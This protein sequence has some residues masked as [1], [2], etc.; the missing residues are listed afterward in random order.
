LFDLEKDPFEKT[1]LAAQNPKVVAEIIA[2]MEREHKAVK[3]WPLLYGE[4]GKE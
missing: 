4:G 1:D 2:I 3:D